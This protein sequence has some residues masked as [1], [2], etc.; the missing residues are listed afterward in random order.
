MEIFQN[1]GSANTPSKNVSSKNKNE[2]VIVMPR[3]E[4]PRAHR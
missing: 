1:M 2:G 4:S 3:N